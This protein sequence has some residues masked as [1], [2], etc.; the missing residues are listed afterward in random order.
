VLAVVLLACGSDQLDVHDAPQAEAPPR[1]AV[2]YDGGWPE[3]AAFIRRE[4][5]DGRP[6]V[7]NILASWCAP[8][9]RELP[10]LNAAASDNPD[11]AF[12]GIDHMDLRENAERFVEEQ[13]ID[14]PTIFDI[15]G[16]VAATV[17]GRAMPTTVFFDRDGQMVSLASG[18]LT[19][20]ALEERLDEIR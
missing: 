3:A 9:E 10:V 8:C 2:L 12:L 11:I 19:E 18:E 17:G 6:V 7:M 20:S 16:D 13:D 15:E 5:E 4:V 1:D 14:F